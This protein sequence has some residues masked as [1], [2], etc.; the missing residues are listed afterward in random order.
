M[1]W[2]NWYDHSGYTKMTVPHSNVIITNKSESKCSIVNE[3]IL[4]KCSAKENKLCFTKEEES[5]C[6]NEKQKD[7]KNEVAYD[8]T[9]YLNVPN[10]WECERDNPDVQ[11]ERACMANVDNEYFS[12]IL[13]TLNE[14]QDCHGQRLSIKKLREAV[15]RIMDEEEEEMERNINNITC[16]NTFQ[17]RVNK[18][19]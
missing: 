11:C 3:K 6:A 13:D 8:V 18:S 10:A 17:S 1:V 12:D 7:A 14:Y 2:L 5:E 4:Q 16:N 9:N 15:R 19:V